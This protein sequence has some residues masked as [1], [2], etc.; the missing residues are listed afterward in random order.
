MKRVGR[1]KF[2]DVKILLVQAEDGK[3]PGDVLIVSQ[4]DARQSRF[5]R[6]N[7]IP[8]RRDQ[9]D[10]VSERGNCDHAMWIVC[11]Q[12]LAA[13]GLPTAPDRGS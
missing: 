13:F 7:H 10:D 8:T 4:G 5:P 12:G 1:I 2:F 6:T 11:Q 9:M 3:A